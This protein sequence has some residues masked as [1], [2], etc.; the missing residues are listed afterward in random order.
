MKKW[1]NRNK[2]NIKPF[3]F[4]AYYTNENQS[5]TVGDYLW[6]YDICLRLQYHNPDIKKHFLDVISFIK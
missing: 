4:K 1:L 2:T 6:G 3:Q 5:N